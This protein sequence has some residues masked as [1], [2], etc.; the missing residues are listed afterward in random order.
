MNGDQGA[1]RMSTW[2]SLFSRFALISFIIIVYP[3]II[4]PLLEPSIKRF[5]NIEINPNPGYVVN[6]EVSGDAGGVLLEVY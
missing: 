5:P 4:N 6:G 1:V 2:N 3:R